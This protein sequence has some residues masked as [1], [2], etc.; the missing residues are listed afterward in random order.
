MAHLQGTSS[1][2]SLYQL[3][4]DNIYA[5][6]VMFSTSILRKK[7]HHIHAHLHHG[8]KIT[9]TPSNRKHELFF[10]LQTPLPFLPLLII[11]P[12]RKTRPEDENAKAA[13]APLP[14]FSS[15]IQK[16]P[17]TPGKTR[18]LNPTNMD[19]K[20]TLNPGNMDKGKSHTHTHTHTH[21][22]NKSLVLLSFTAY[23]QSKL[24]CLAIVPYEAQIKASSFLD[25]DF[26]RN[27]ARVNQQPP[28][29]AAVGRSVHR[30]GW[31]SFSHPAPDSQ[32]TNIVTTVNVLWLNLLFIGKT[33]L[34]PG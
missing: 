17:Q 6:R 27:M 11:K 9:Q 16:P 23:S 7:M 4:Q 28:L 3:S 25:R 2:P 31:P 8:K 24:H 1:S 21:K 5:H 32:V 30:M 10:Q 13:K 29:T 18:T 26:L 19:K 22:K 33:F 34:L 12:H 15:S 14:F 20:K